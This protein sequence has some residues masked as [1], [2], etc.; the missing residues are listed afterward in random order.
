[1]ATIFTVLKIELALSQHKSQQSV[2]RQSGCS[3]DYSAPEL[4]PWVG[5][6]GYNE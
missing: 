6:D 1:M 5:K 4:N 3:L 2:H